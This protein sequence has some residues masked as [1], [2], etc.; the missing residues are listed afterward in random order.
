MIFTTS[1]VLRADIGRWYGPV[2]R[3]IDELFTINSVWSSGK[4]ST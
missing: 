3:W 2:Q 1:W 4:Q